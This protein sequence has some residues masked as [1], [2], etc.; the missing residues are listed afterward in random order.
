MRVL[1]VN[2]G[3]TGTKLSVVDASSG[4]ARDL[5]GDV[6]SVARRERPDAVG[7]RVAHGGERFLGPARIE[8]PVRDEIEALTPLAPLHQPPALRGIDEARAALP[9]VLQVACFDTAFHASMPPE[10]YL[11]ALPLR[12]RERLAIRRYGFHGLSVAHAAPRAAEMVGR[13]VGD[14]RIVVCHLGGGASVTAVDRGRSVDTTMGY[15][16]LEGLVMA[17]RAGSVDAAAVIALA[18]AGLG[19]DEVERVLDRESGLLGLT[20]TADMRRVLARA[21]AGDA[22][23]SDALALYAHRARAAITGCAAAMG[24]L[25]ALVFTGGVGEHSGEV[26]ARICDRLSFVG[27]SLHPARNAA[28]DGTRDE[29]V[30]DG[31][32]PVVV[33]HAREELVIARETARVAAR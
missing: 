24:G 30:D 3:S 23:A 1:V 21:H 27:V 18:R 31:E 19:P 12:W 6:E 4:A 25:D 13:D 16:P 29:R 10:A 20:G 22:A 11:Y 33:V 26:R 28:A 32:V 9:D 14:L 15:S 17:T 7:H 5:E 8:G 2:A